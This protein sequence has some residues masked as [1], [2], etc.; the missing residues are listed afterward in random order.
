MEVR[1]TQAG[2]SW[3]R[4][5]LKAQASRAVSAAHG[6]PDHVV[7]NE[8]VPEPPAKA[9]SVARVWSE[10]APGP[11]GEN[12]RCRIEG[13]MCSL[14]GARCRNPERRAIAPSRA[15]VAPPVQLRRLLT[16]FEVRFT[17]AKDRRCCETIL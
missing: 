10:Q 17:A 7:G 13:Q 11:V 9:G 14:K 5:G 2:I 3:L 12:K 1:L 16:S 15:I 4:L 6:Q 8:E